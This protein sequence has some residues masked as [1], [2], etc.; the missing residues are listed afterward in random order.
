MPALLT[1]KPA[2]GAVNDRTGGRNDH[3]HGQDI[4][5]WGI[6]PCPK[7][8]NPWFA[9][10]KRSYWRHCPQVGPDHLRD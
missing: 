1:T 4:E 8:G 7:W 10:A 5:G 9:F 6:T 2:G 3:P